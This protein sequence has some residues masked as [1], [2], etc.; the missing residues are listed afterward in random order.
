MKKPA[1]VIGTLVVSLLIL[2]VLAHHVDM[3]A[4]HHWVHGSWEKCS[5]RVKHLRWGRTSGSSLLLRDFLAEKRSLHWKT[6]I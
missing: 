1:I 4:L 2:V 5:A 3:Q 6:K